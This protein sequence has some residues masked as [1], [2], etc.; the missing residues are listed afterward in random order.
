ME[1]DGRGAPISVYREFA[2]SPELRDHVRALAWYGPASEATGWRVPTRELY[3][4]DDGALAPTVADAHASLLFALGVSYSAK[5]WQPCSTTDVTVMGAVTRATQP[6]SVERSGMIGVYL[7]PR[8][9]AALFG[10]S[11][12]ELTDRII[13]VGDLWKG[14]PAEPGQARLETVEALLIRRLSMASLPDRA[15]RI[16]NLA[17]YV[18]RC[19]GRVSVSQMA[20]LS[21]CTR[22]HLRRLFLEYVGVTPKCY[23]RLARFRSGLRHLGDRE[24][25]G[26]WSRFAARLGYADQSHLIAE[27]REFSG[28]TPDQLARGERFHPF[29]GD[30]EGHAG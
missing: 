25:V 15:A 9:S 6:P 22:Q 29:I 28:F 23:A 11:K 14:F 13:P 4:G 3:V 19:G 16:A 30:S 21:G 27:F 10:I 5:G 12:T 7:R 26:G 1:H 2:P 24:R 18:R 20:D 8:G 17:S